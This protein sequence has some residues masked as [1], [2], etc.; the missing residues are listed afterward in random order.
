MSKF[1]VGTKPCE[2]VVKIITSPYLRT[3][4]KKMSPAVQTSSVEA[5]HSVVN[6]FAPKMLSFTHEG[7]SCRLAE[8]ILHFFTVLIQM[9][10]YN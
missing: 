9:N 2:K 7:M 10:Y 1:H 5:F 8:I 4:V 6:H 3:D